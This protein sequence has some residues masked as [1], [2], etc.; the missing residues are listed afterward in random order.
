M[1]VRCALC[2]STGGVG[3]MVVRS[4]SPSWLASKS[5]AGDSSESGM[6]VAVVMGGYRCGGYVGEATRWECLAKQ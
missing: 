1:A 3:S 2:E 4:A 6:V 5:S